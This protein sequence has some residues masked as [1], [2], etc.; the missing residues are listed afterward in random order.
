ML[1]SSLKA[2][3]MT[4]EDLDIVTQISV[5][6]THQIGNCQGSVC[7]FHAVV[8]RMGSKSTTTAAISSALI[9]TDQNHIDQSQPLVHPKRSL[10]Q[11][12]TCRRPH[13]SPHQHYPNLILQLTR[14]LPP[15]YQKQ[16]TYYYVSSHPS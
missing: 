3:S 12:G 14:S 10:Q 11:Y 15:S 1:Y 7:D 2:S 6:T 5:A 13:P 8:Q 4:V 9:H 16:S